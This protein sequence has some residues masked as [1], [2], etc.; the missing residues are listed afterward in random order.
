M[1]RILA[2]LLLM[3]ISFNLYGVHT[4]AAGDTNSPFDVERKDFDITDKSNETSLVDDSKLDGLSTKI[5]SFFPVVI[6]VG[7][8]VIAVLFIVGVVG[9]IFAMITKNGQWTQLST[10]LMLFSFVTML[11]FR[12]GPYLLFSKGVESLLDLVPDFLG[13]IQTIA[14]IAVP[15]MLVIGIRLYGIFKAVGQPEFY[16]WSKRIMLGS[17]LLF[18]VAL[19]TPTIFLKM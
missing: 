14:L 6:K 10:G 4:Y 16:R 12:V 11:L 5:D 13:F 19:V 2:L 1:K 17:V 9:M 7:I 18:I 3:T 15:F 8:Q